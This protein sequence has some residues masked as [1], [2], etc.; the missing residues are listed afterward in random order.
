MQEDKQMARNQRGQSAIEYTLGVGCVVA[1][2]ALA[3]IVVGHIYADSFQGQYGANKY[4]LPNAKFDE[5]SRRMKT[6]SA[7]FDLN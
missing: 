7:T 4:D 3:L 6:A 1:I 2:S 5:S